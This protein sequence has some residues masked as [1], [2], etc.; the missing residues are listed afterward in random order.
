M[1]MIRKETYGTVLFPTLPDEI[2]CGK[3]LK[4]FTTR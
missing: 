3:G 1:F 2:T 4:P